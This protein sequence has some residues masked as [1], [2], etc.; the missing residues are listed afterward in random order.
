MRNRISIFLIGLLL[1]SVLATG[2]HLHVDNKPHT[3]CLICVASS[4]SLAVADNGS[5]LF[6]RE[7]VLPFKAQEEVL[8]L[9]LPEEV[10]SPSRAPPTAAALS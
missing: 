10:S 9:P 2:F 4:H 3:E 5:N 8:Y 6:H 7:I 1:F